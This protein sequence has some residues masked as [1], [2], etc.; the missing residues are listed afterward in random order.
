MAQQVLLTPTAPEQLRTATDQEI[1]QE[2]GLVKPDDLKVSLQDDPQLVALAEKYASDLMN[3][4]P[5][6][7]AKQAAGRDAV[8]QMGLPVQEEVARRS[9][10]LKEPIRTLVKRGGDDANVANSLI[11]LKLEVEKHDPNEFDFEPGWFARLVGRTPV[12]GDKIKEYFTQWEEAETLIDAVARSLRMGRDQLHRDCGVL[13]ADQ[14]EMRKATLKVQKLIKIGMLMDNSFEQKLGTLSREE[15]QKKFIEEELVFPLRQRINALQTQLGFA[16]MG[17]IGYETIIRTNLELIRGID[18]A[19]TTTIMGL[20]VATVLSLALAH[21]KDQLDKLMAV[22]EVTAKLFV[23]TTERLRKQGVDIQKQASGEMI[24]VEVMKTAFTNLRA[25]LDDLSRFRREALPR[26][27]Q[28]IRDFDL[29]TTE[30]EKA[31]QDMERG[32]KVRSQFATM[33]EVKE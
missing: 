32:T 16:Q 28:S 33:I 5:E 14:I 13:R 23:E 1:A 8:E 9:A 30:A 11:Q 21:Q 25:S 18:L 4:N 17:V 31:I 7:Y 12:L 3:I 29:L 20:R 15:Q 27:A 24:A 6:D 19:L 26:M 22:N 10:M 2:L